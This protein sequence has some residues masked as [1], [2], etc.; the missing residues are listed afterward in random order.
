MAYDQSRTIHHLT[1]EGWVHGCVRPENALETWICSTHQQS[2]WSKED[3]DWSCEWANALVSRA[4]RD[5]VRDLF[6]SKIGMM[7]GTRGDVRI[8]VGNPL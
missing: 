2:S 3:R 6:A 5:K 4:E 1:V 7:A 8:T